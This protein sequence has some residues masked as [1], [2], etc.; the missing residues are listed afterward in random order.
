LQNGGNSLDQKK[1]LISL[2]FILS[3]KK[4]RLVIF[5]IELKKKQKTL[6]LELFFFKGWN[7]YNY[8][9]KIIH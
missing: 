7:Y 9:K 5:K 8:L 6:M 2:I 4:I 1:K 3:F